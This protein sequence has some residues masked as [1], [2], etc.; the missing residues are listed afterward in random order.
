LETN[1]FS[2]PPITTYAKK[3]SLN[4]DRG[5]FCVSYYRAYNPPMS[6]SILTTKLYI[7][8][9]RPEL[10]SRPRLIERLNEGLHRKLTLILGSAGF[11]KTIGATDRS[12]QK[13]KRRTMNDET[14]EVLAPH[15]PFRGDKV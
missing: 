2:T 4:D 7:P 5:S 13:T 11:G 9:I 3:K 1:D 10:V 12:H 14:Y 15:A 8:P 6:T